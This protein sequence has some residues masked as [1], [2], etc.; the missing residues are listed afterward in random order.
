MEISPVGCVRGLKGSV[1]LCV[2]CT[3]Q[4]REEL[5]MRRNKKKIIKAQLLVRKALKQGGGKAFHT[6]HRILFVCAKQ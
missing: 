3:L 5:Q 2:S 1:G 4:H 6:S